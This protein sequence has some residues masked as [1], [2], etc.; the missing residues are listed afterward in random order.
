M[1]IENEIKADEPS[2]ETGLNGL[3]EQMLPILQSASDIC[4]A[5]TSLIYMYQD[6]DFWILASCG[7]PEEPVVSAIQKISGIVEPGS[8]LSIIQNIRDHE[9][10]ATQ[11][12]DSEMDE[13]QFFAGAFFRNEA[14][15]N[16]GAFCICDSEPLELSEIQK[17]QLRVLADA[18]KA[19]LMLHKQTELSN[20]SS[21]KLEIS[22][23]LLKNSAD[24]TFILEP[25]SGK[26]DHV[27][28]GVEKVLGYSPDMLEGIPFTDILEA[29]EIEG[30][31]IDEWFSTEKQHLGRFSTS[32]RFMDYQGRKRWFQCNFSFDKNHWYVTATDITDKKVAEQGVYELQD[33]LTQI[34]SVAT[35]L[36]Y[37][38][39]WET[40]DLSWGDELTDVLGYPNSEKFVNYDW[41]LDKIHPD[42]LKQVIDD[43]EDTVE[44]DSLKMKSVYRIRTFDGSYKYVMNRIYVDRNEEGAPKDIVGAIVDI[45]ELTEINQQSKTNKRLLEEKNVLM[46]EIH[47]R[48][49]NNLA[50]VSAMLTLQALNETDEQVQE[51]LHASTGRIKTMATIHELLY[52]SSSFVELR[53]DENIEQI[54]TS[55]AGTFNVSVDLDLSYSMEPVELNLDD[56][57]PCSLIV[58]E[59]ITNIL[60]YAYSDGDSGVLDVSLT[61]D[62]ETVTLKIRDDGKG[63]PD[64]FSYEGN[65]TSLGMMLIQTLTKQLRG[66]FSY[67]SLERG[68]EFKLVFDKSVG[69]DIDLKLDENQ[70][71]AEK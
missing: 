14:G 68:V 8:G 39:N 60:K 59:V 5:A 65:G 71:K 67:T 1:I 48:V 70:I 34:V 17:Q 38:L 12:T 21:R 42:D 3:R 31:R 36:I 7:D 13:I 52:K 49:K 45:S 33:R 62:G 32:I 58:N 22:S 69:K 43:V 37:N 25:E 10:A 16:I 56:A 29:D 4:E 66:T 27:S 30:N 6:S 51:K 46:A 35:D 41:W 20:E 53:I 57:L 40:K 9:Q 64:D 61:G 2:T 55:L 23:A 47:H 63:L 54:I 24:L 15:N 11:L 44:G 26:I 18:A 19:H 28:T 50:V